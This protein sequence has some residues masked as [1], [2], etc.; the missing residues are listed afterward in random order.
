[1]SSSSAPSR[2]DYSKIVVADDAVEDANNNHMLG[3]SLMAVP[4]AVVAAPTQPM[5][6]IT[7]PA[8]MPEGYEF[9]AAIGSGDSTI[10]NGQGNDNSDSNSAATA[11]IKVQVPPGGIEKG[12]TFSVPFP[13]QMTS[14]LAAAATIRIPVGNWRDGLF[15]WWKHGVCHPHCW[16]ACCCSTRTFLVLLFAL[17]DVLLLENQREMA[18]PKPDTRSRPQLEMLLLFSPPPVAAGQV[19]SRMGLDWTGKPARTPGQAAAAFTIIMGIV[20]T[21]YAVRI[22]LG[23]T[24]N[25]VANDDDEEEDSSSNEGSD[26]D[27]DDDD[28]DGDFVSLLILIWFSLFW[29]VMCIL[30]TRVRKTVRERYGIPANKLGEVWEDPIVSCCCCCFSAGQMLRHTTEYDTYPATCCT[31]TGIPPTAPSIV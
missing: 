22:P 1:M 20:L 24:F 8:D 31:R 3:E 10:G 19:M 17:C 30:L 15:D 23:I 6:Q 12:Q 14:Q 27:D 25:I 21:Y 13:A 29:V 2:S 18:L 4:T 9:D 26:K 7:A 5:L 28:E 16:T 11:T